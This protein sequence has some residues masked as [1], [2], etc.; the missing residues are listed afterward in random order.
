MV[1]QRIL[2]YNRH[3]MDGLWLQKSLSRWGK[4]VKHLTLLLNSHWCF[5]SLAWESLHLATLLPIWEGIR[6]LYVE[7]HCHW[8][9]YRTIS[10]RFICRQLSPIAGEVVMQKVTMG[11]RMAGQGMITLRGC[12]LWILSSHCKGT[13]SLLLRRST[14]WRTVWPGVKR[15]MISPSVGARS[16]G[17]EWNSECQGGGII[18]SLRPNGSVIHPSYA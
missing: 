7:I 10:S 14:H 17:G 12:S 13:G 3:R 15:A 16:T 18:A 8:R 1:T 6:R 4:Q 5:S 2:G 9:G 11:R